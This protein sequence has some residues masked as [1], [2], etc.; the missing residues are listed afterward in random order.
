MY[1]HELNWNLSNVITGIII[2]PLEN[3][4]NNVTDV[5]QKVFAYVIELKVKVQV[6]VVKSLLWFILVQPKLIPSPTARS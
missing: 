5:A 3:V 1:C 4:I 6:S 2:P